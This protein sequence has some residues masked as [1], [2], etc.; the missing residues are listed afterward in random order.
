MARIAEIIV[1]LKA[2]G[3]ATLGKLSDEVKRLAASVRSTEAPTNDA[4]GSLDRFRGR[5]DAVSGVAGKLSLALG[6][7]SPEAQALVNVFADL[8]DGAVGL[9]EGAKASG[10][11]FTTL[12][13]AGV[14]LAAGLAVVGGAYVHIT[15]ALEREVAEAV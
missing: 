1:R 7:V 11:S 13:A 4:A 12:A 2:E 6:V 5:A 9:A 8:G 3:A 10:V 14:G 15:R